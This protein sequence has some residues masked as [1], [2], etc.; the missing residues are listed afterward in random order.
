MMINYNWGKCPLDNESSDV[1]YMQMCKLRLG[2]V[3]NNYKESRAAWQSR[4]SGPVKSSVSLHPS[5]TPA[6]VERVRMC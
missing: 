5:Q 1:R 6:C 2:I 3:Y 4:N